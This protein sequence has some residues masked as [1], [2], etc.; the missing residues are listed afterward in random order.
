MHL[1]LFGNLV[2]QDL[3]LSDGT[4]LQAGMPR[5][6]AVTV[7]AHEA[8]AAAAVHH[9]LAWVHPF[10]DG[11]GRVTRLQTQLA[12]HAQGLTN[13]LWSPLRSFARTEANY[14]VSLKAADEHRPGDFEM[15]STG[16]AT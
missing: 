12:L 6:R 10:L 2:P 5:T 9:R 4:L 11:N 7:A 3:A 14:K 1:Q 16:A 8:P 15:I 13:G